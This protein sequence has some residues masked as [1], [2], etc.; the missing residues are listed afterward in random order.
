MQDTNSQILPFTGFVKVEG[1]TF[2]IGQTKK[3]I[4]LPEFYIGIYPV[5]QTF[6]SKIMGSNPSGFKGKNNPV[7]SVSWNDL[8][9]DNGFLAKL[10]GNIE[11]KKEV[12]KHF[13]ITPSEKIEFRLPSE[14]EWEYAARGGIHNSPDEYA[15]S[16]DINEVAWYRENSP[17][18][19]MPVGLKAPNQLG[20]Y[21]MSGNV[22]EWCEDWWS[23]KAKD[24]PEDGT[25][26]TKT[27]DSR[28]LRG[29]GY[30]YVAGDCGVSVRGSHRPSSRGSGIGFRLAFSFQEK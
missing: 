21:D 24:I 18:S 28:V 16:K 26:N 3:K 11:I 19:T 8:R 15:G 14:T 1:G 5:T 12:A 6:Y 29:G 2:T 9:Q 7:E 22:W 25:A 20:L 30:F 10:N 23:D 4:T 17:Q 13:N 27:G